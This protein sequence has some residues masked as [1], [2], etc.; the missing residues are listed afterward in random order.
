VA[1]G[2]QHLD[3]H[4]FSLL[5]RSLADLA[6]RLLSLLEEPTSAEQDAAALQGIEAWGFAQW[7]TLDETLEGI[8]AALERRE[9]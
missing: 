4:A 6:A 8:A 2:P 3:H 9:R 7:A 5:R 1:T